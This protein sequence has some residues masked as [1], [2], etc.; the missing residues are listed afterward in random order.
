MAVLHHFVLVLFRRDHFEAGIDADDFRYGATLPSRE[1]LSDSTTH[2][3]LTCGRQVPFGKGELLYQFVGNLGKLAIEAHDGPVEAAV[4]SLHLAEECF[5][6]HLVT[7]S[8]VFEKDRV[9][10][11]QTASARVIEQ[12][13]VHDVEQIVWTVQNDC[14]AA[15]HWKNFKVALGSITK[16]FTREIE[17]FSVIYLRRLKSQCMAMH[18]DRPLRYTN[19]PIG[20]QPFADMVFQLS[21]LDLLLFE[22]I[23]F[24][25]VESYAVLGQIH[26]T[27]Q[28][29]DS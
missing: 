25:C 11:A 6:S 17:T 5:C 20:F 23:D 21:T 13:M 7:R 16:F 27:I 18:D 15:I 26:G 1:Y 22:F 24:F 4:A 9:G 28:Q 10:E 12:N 29:E 14:V 3:Q 2:Q 8:Q 19:F